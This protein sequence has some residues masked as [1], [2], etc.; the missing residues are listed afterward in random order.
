MLCVFENECSEIATCKFAFSLHIIMALPK[1]IH[2]SDFKKINIYYCTI[3][4]Y[5]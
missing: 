2:D 5:R 4:H 1:F 3:K